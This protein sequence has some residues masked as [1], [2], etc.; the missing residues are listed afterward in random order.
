[1]NLIRLCWPIKERERDFSL[2]LSTPTRDLSS[3][4]CSHGFRPVAPIKPQPVLSPFSAPSTSL[5]IFPSSLLFLS[6]LFLSH[7][8]PWKPWCDLRHR[9]NIDRHALRHED[10]STPKELGPL[11]LSVECHHLRRWRHVRMAT[12]CH[13]RV[14]VSDQH[15]WRSKPPTSSFLPHDRNGTFGSQQKLL[16]CQTRFRMR[17]VKTL[18][19]NPSQTRP[20]F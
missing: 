16:D 13:R 5:S 6:S 14:T 8:R 2:P 12:A 4:R 3:S 19:V 20:Y 10:Q 18:T 15:G 1:M 11:P 9:G 7:R 17:T